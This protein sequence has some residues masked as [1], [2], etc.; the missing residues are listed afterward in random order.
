M[1]DCIRKRWGFWHD[2]GLTTT[3][4]SW[5][6]VEKYGKTSL[7]HAW[8]AHISAHFR[9]ILLGVTQVAPGW[10]EIRFAP[11]YA[12]VDAVSGVIP[13][14]QGNISVEIDYAAGKKN[15]SLPQGIMMVE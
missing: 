13:T 12:G 9:D 5:A 11:V 2:L 3:P 8:S 15:I 1:I 7:C 10:K 4:E 14:P 6:T